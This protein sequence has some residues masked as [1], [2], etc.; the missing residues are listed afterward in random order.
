[1]SL[2][3]KQG[4]GVQARR[5]RECHAIPE[6]A[7]T[8]PI[9]GKERQRAS[10]EDLLGAGE[11]KRV[12][13]K[14][15]EAPLLGGHLIDPVALLGHLPPGHLGGGKDLFQVK[16]VTTERSP[17]TREQRRG[18]SKPYSGNS[19]PGTRAIILGGDIDAPEGVSAAGYQIG[20]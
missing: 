2:Q 18:S 17:P 12:E 10:T 16:G 5:G 19:R 11:K 14:V 13:E 4:Q 15:N 8:T 3:R 1:M 7:G 9:E 20:G 6:G